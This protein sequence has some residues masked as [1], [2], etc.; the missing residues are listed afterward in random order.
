MQDPANMCARAASYR[1]HEHE[2]DRADHKNIEGTAAPND[3]A[4]KRGSWLGISDVC[5]AY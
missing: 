5:S 2:L 3:L 1:P 4:I